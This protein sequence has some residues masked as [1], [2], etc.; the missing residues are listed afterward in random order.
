LRKQLSLSILVIPLL[1]VAALLKYVTLPLIPLAAI[2]LWRRAEGRERRARVFAWSAVLSLAALAVALFPFYDLRAAWASVAGQGTIVYTSPASAALVL[3]R[4]HFPTESI[5]PWLALAGFGGV[6]IA[7]AYQAGALSRRPARLPLACFEVL[8][9]FLLLAVWNLRPWYLI[10]LVG[11]AAL[12]WSADDERARWPAWR[13]I[14]WTIG[15]LASY[16]FLIWV[17]AW[18]QPGYD[19][20]QLVGVA[21]LVAPTVLVTLAQLASLRRARPAVRT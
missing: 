7:W 15:G 10:W 17:E 1:V 6:L 14:A 3:L 2:A 5:R 11:L 16:G 20:T 12:L 4:R 8:Y 13:A 21:V 18:W 9:V 19:L